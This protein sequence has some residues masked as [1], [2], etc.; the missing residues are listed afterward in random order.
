M[1]SSLE[2]ADKL[3]ELAAADG[4]SLTP[5]QLI[6]LVYI[7]HGWMLG[8]Y[9][10]RLISDDVQAWKYG[11]VIPKLYQAVKNFRDQAV[12]GPL[13]EDG[14]AFDE[15]EEDLIRQVYQAYGAR[16]GIALSE[17]THRS[18]TP[19][20]STVKP[21]GWGLVISD[22]LIEQHYKELATRYGSQAQ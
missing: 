20:H 10:E 9:G 2:V 3:L 13:S 16:S 17:L 11:P 22:D 4:R 5:M 7:C 18:G 8:L 1:H 15:I 19:W 12:T 14:T 21:S 6:K